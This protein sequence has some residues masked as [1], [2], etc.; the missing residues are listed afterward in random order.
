MLETLYQLDEELELILDA[1]ESDD[2]QSKNF[3]ESHLEEHL[4]PRIE[5]KIDL[6]T[7]AIRKYETQVKY[8]KEEAQ[9]IQSLANTNETTVKWLKSKL[10]EFMERRFE[11][12][13]ERGKKLE[14]KLS[15]VSLC[16]NGGL[17]PIWINPNLKEQDFPQEYLEYVPRLKRT[18]LIDATINLGEIRDLQ[19]RLIAKVMPRNY[20]LRI[21]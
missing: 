14:G 13:G 3:A 21:K 20:H 7:T 6:Y 4:F 9:R 19:G 2:E 10:Q 8:Q 15:K 12:L 17:P 16:L 1:L 11:Q 5:E 18:E